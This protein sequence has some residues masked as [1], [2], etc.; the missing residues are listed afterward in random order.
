MVYQPISLSFVEWPPLS[1]HGTKTSMTE[2][3]QRGRRWRC[4]RPVEIW[5][6]FCPIESHRVSGLVVIFNMNHPTHTLYLWG[7]LKRLSNPRSSKNK[8]WMVGTWDF[9]ERGL[10][11]K[12]NVVEKKAGSRRSTMIHHPHTISIGF[13]ASI[14]MGGLWHCFT[15]ITSSKT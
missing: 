1:L 9:S 6:N 8:F 15:N 2:R 3:Q 13:L 4:I 10:V 11:K 5:S 14:H 7:S 12:K